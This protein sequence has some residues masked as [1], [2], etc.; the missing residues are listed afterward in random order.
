MKNFCSICCKSDENCQDKCST[1]HSFFKGHDPEEMFISVCSKENMGPAFQNF[2][3]SMIVDD[4]KDEYNQCFTNF[5]FDCCSNELKITDFNDSEIQ[6]CLKICKEGK[7]KTGVEDSK[8]PTQKK[9]SQ[10]KKTNSKPIELSDEIKKILQKPSEEKELKANDDSLTRDLNKNTVI[11]EIGNEDSKEDN[12]TDKN[13]L[14]EEKIINKKEENSSK[15]S[16]SNEKKT[17][18]LDNQKII[19]VKL[20]DKLTRKESKK[21]K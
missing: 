8:K 3:G 20:N 17:Y 12:N 14:V 19:D 13:K 15:I 9:E 2:C 21:F 6:K 11:K 4:N 5:C 10:N 1:T 18:S 7:S 16:P